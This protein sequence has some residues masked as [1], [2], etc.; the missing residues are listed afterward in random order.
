[1]TTPEQDPLEALKTFWNS[2]GFPLPGLIAPPLDTDE[3]SRRI[4]DFKAVE[5]WLKANLAT[6]Q[7]TIQ[8]LEMQQ[9]AL[10]AVRNATRPPRQPE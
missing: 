8:A 6:L 2:T 10:T 1:M 9:A 3:L 4:A 5:G 7:M